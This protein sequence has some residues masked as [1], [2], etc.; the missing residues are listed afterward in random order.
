MFSGISLFSWF[1]ACGAALAVLCLY[2]ARKKTGVS[3]ETVGWTVVLALPLGAFLGHMLYGVLL[4][5][6]EVTVYGVGFL[7]QPWMGGFMY[8]GAVLG[9]V[10]SAW[11]VTRFLKKPQELAGMLDLLGIALL[12]LI[13]VIRLGEPFDGRDGYGQGYGIPMEDMTLLPV[14]FKTLLC[15]VIDPDYMDEWYLGV[16][17]LEA[18]WALAALIWCWRGLRRRPAG[19]TGLLALVLY[20]GGQMFFEF[21][22]RDFTVNWRFVRLS[23]LISAILLAVI[24]L[25]ATFQKRV[26]GKDA[27]A[28]W[29]GMLALTGLV[30]AMEFADEKPLVLSEETMIFFP[31]WFT[32]GV[33]LLCAVGMGLIAWHS[34]ANKK[35]PGKPGPKS[36]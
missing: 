12:L 10:L 14:P 1:V 16:F 35:E 8:Y 29:I 7:F 9:A 25:W 32:Y 22:R 18:M 27:L 23:Q 26:R 36:T 31:H 19:K 30:I 15:Y 33:L 11:A 13:A 20:A 34:H 17:A 24:L 3:A 21:L 28:H 5:N 6:L 2:C 4:A